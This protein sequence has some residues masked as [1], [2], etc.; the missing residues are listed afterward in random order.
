MLAQ[1]L[2]ESLT[3]FDTDANVVPQNHQQMNRGDNRV[4]ESLFLVR[5]CYTFLRST[6]RVSN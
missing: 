1:N 5:T 6:C 4:S 2:G 3:N